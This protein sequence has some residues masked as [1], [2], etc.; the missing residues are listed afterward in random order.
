[1]DTIIEAQSR[2]RIPDDIAHTVIDPASYRDEDRIHAAFRWLRAN[3]PLGIAEVPGY[4]PIWIVTRMADIRA[5]ER[6]P[7]LFASAGANP[8]LNNRASDAFTRSIN[9]GSLRIISSLTFMD[10]PEHAAFRAVTQSWFLPT[11]IRQL[12][13]DIRRRARQSVAEMLD[14]DGECDFVKDVALHYPLRVILSM[15]GV[16]DRDYPRMLKLTQEFFGGNDP[17]EQRSEF[18]DDPLVAAKMWAATLEDFYAYFDEL[19][20][21]RRAHPTDDLISIIANSQVNGAPIPRN[22]ANGYYVAI[23]TAGHDTT[24]SSSAGAV[25]GL[26]A[27]PENLARLHADPALIPG[28]LDE[29]IRWTS[30]VKHF[31]RNATRDTQLAGQDI[32]AMDRFFLAYPSANRDEAV[33]TDPD[34]FDITRTPNNHAAF[35]FG[36]HMCLGQHLAKL[37][38]KI[39]FEELLPHLAHVELAGEPRMVAANFVGGYKSLP[40]RFRKR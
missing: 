22:E 18:V 21:E 36:P 2:P 30:P 27:F 33:F 37:E 28:L 24:S 15:F 3:M 11:R 17:E 5:I 25:H 7:H 14:F 38:M 12:E 9:G 1:M 8:I 35:G 10:P 39:L 4:D 16:P 20:A 19:S 32:A 6:D 23:A 26:A 13:T 29:A 34:A 31:M 40:I